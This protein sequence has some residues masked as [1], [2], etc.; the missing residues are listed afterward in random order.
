MGTLRTQR[1]PGKH[2]GQIGWEVALGTT[3]WGTDRIFFVLA[4]ATAMIAQ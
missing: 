3:L 4:V 2:E 1:E